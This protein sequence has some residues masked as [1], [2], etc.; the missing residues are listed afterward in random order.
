MT[1]ECPECDSSEV[2]ITTWAKLIQND[3]D[4]NFH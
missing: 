1:W 3:D 4:E 2:V